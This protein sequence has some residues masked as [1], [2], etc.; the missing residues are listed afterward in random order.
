[1]NVYEGSLDSFDYTNY[2]SILKRNNHNFVRLWAQ[3][4]A[5]WT[6]LPYS[7]PGPGVAN[8]GKPKFDLKGFNQSYFD[9]LRSK[10]IAARDR[11]IYVSVMLFQ[12]WSVNNSFY[13]SGN[14]VWSTHPFNASN[15]INGINGDTNGDGEGEATY[16]WVNSA[17]TAIQDAYVKKV[18]DTVNDL[19]NVLLEISNESRST[20]KIGSI[21]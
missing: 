16:T 21:T 6:P 7:R 15:N 1:M 10:V 13:S 3:E 20:S 19:D 4:N 12:G 18:I 17:I 8:D 14:D 2:L 11:G 5:D 9:N